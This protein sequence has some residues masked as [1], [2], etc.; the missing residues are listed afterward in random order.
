[1]THF[2]IHWLILIG[3]IIG[4]VLLIGGVCLVMTLQVTKTP[5]IEAEGTDRGARE[6][7]ADVTDSTQ[8]AELT[9]RRGGAQAS[10]S[11]RPRRPPML[12]IIMLM[13]V[14]CALGRVEFGEVRG[15]F[16]CE[17][18]LQCGRDSTFHD[19]R[20][21]VYPLEATGGWTT[22]PWL[23]AP[24][25]A[26]DTLPGPTTCDPGKI[27]QC[28]VL[29]GGNLTVSVR[30]TPLFW[31][32][33]LTVHPVYEF[34][35]NYET[36]T[37]RTPGNV[38]DTRV[39]CDRLR[40]HPRLFG[41]AGPC[42]KHLCADGGEVVD[43]ETVG[44]GPGCGL[45]G[46]KNTHAELV[47][48][49][50]VEVTDTERSTTTT[51]VFDVVVSGER[52]QNPMGTMHAHVDTY[53]VPGGENW[54][55][56]HR[57]TGGIAVCDWH[58]VWER[59]APRNT[60]VDALPTP[61]PAT[62]DAGWYYVSPARILES[63]GLR[64]CGMNGPA[65]SEL[66]PGLSG[67]DCALGPSFELGECLPATY[68]GDILNGTAWA[69]EYVPP[70][71]ASAASKVGLWERTGARRGVLHLAHA[72]D[73]LP[74]ELSY[75]VVLR[76]AT[77]IA[78]TDKNNRHQFHSALC[79]EED[80]LQCVQDPQSLI[81][82]INGTIG[83]R[84]PNANATGVTATLSCSYHDGTAQNV[85]VTHV[86]RSLG[87]LGSG[88]S[89][90]VASVFG[91]PDAGI[92]YDDTGTPVGRENAA[93]D[94]VVNLDTPLGAYNATYT[95]TG[96]VSCSQ[97]AKVEF[98]SSSLYVDCNKADDEFACRI[99]HGTV[100]EST[101]HILY[102]GIAAILVCAD[103]AMIWYF[104]DKIRAARAQKVPVKTQVTPGSK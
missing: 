95:W 66:A 20:F 43:T 10:T 40:Y 53:T 97:L 36:S 34:P 1:M 14:A 30:A 89:A 58:A 27:G 35:S 21:R 85:T 71:W 45:F 17:P 42:W 37:V 86:A 78:R 63:Y 70:N 16:P 6:A 39:E 4:V 64:A 77:P 48:G 60:P 25:Q 74:G 12:T 8:I 81:V 88:K 51:L 91:M 68:P 56:P 19:L 83:N 73:F 55:Y 65:L 80:S 93:F 75:E 67:Y 13:L 9:A 96:T 57:L 24:Y 23:F 94:C 52:R 90:G 62:Q 7:E 54:V 47:A 72:S 104:Y 101:G 82:R 3:I 44:V 41:D 76:V 99:H 15:R 69:P 49:F 79:L 5:E 61:E 84:S 102:F 38:T 92:R 31:Y 50:E 2:F 26:G 100:S 22:T 18:G 98:E 59:Y 29:N 87:T 11:M 103:V 33:P 28:Y 46:F 32:N